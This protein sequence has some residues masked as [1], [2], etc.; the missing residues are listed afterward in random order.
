MSTATDQ[1]SQAQARRRARVDA[2][3]DREIDEVLDRVGLSEAAVQ[4][5]SESGVD[6]GT[7]NVGPVAREKLKGIINRLRTKAHPFTTCM[8]DLRE[9]KPEWSED[10]RK[11]TCN[12]LKQLAGRGSGGGGKATAMSLDEVTCAV[13][14][15]VMALI[16]H[17]DIDSFAEEI[18]EE[19]AD[20]LAQLTAKKRKSLPGRAFVFAGSRRYPI[21]DLAHARNALARA[22]GKPEEA[23]VKAAV[24]KKFP[25]LKPSN[26]AA[27]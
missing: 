20:Q 3:V 15:G 10:R 9:H 2:S 14:D 27:D 18:G 13:D 19:A 8:S 1:L 11:K 5:L 21:H 24:Y 23:A 4:R 7:A 25:Q 17:I 26:K 6:L 22:S 12:V 16:E